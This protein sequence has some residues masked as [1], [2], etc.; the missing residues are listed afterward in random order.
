MKRKLNEVDIPEEVHSAPPS[1]SSSK[2]ET[3]Q[4]DPR[5]LRGIQAQSWANPTKVQ[6][7]AIPLAL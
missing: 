3:F 6:L 4:L 5:I 2:F 7:E 1:K